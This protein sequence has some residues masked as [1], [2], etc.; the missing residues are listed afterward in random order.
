MWVKLGASEKSC[1]F[2]EKKFATFSEDGRVHVI[3][4]YSIWCG[5]ES[6]IPVYAVC[7]RLIDHLQEKWDALPWCMCTV[8]E[9]GNSNK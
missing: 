1:R 7:K 5:C 4:Q 9:S 8:S 6:N 2:Y 3:R